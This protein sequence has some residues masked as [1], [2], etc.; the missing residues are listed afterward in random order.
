MRIT[1]IAVRNYRLHRD[2]QIALDPS[3][4][5]IGGLNE[6][7]K[8]TLI[9]AAHRALFLK[10][11][12]NTKEHRAM[13]SDIHSGHP[14][15]EVEFEAR[16]KSWRI[17]KRFSGGSGTAKLTEAGGA[18]LPGDEAETRLRELLGVSEE[19]GK[20]VEQWAH[21]WVWQGSAGENPAEHASAQRDA[22]LARLQKDG[23]A[24]VMRSALDA[25]VA[26][27]VED[28]C[29]LI[30]K[31]SGEAKAGSAP[32]RAQAE[33]AEAEQRLSAAREVAARLEQAAQEFRSAEAAILQSSQSFLDLRP[34]QES[35]EQRAARLVILTGREK[36]Q[37]T[38]VKLAADRLLVLV[39][40]DKNL[41]AL[42][43]DIQR[44]R[45]SLEPGEKDAEEAVAQE[46]AGRE[47]DKKA[48]HSLNAA[49]EAVRAARLCSELAAAHIQCLEKSAAREQLRV[50]LAEV[51]KLRAALAEQEKKLAELPAVDAAALKRLQKLDSE[52][53]QAAAALEAMAARLE[54]IAAGTSVQVEGRTL[55]A[56]ERLILTEDSEVTVGDATRLRIRP[57]G[58]TGLTEA[59]QRV[60]EADAA[61]QRTLDALG[62]RSVTE[63]NEAG[64]LRQQLETE[65]K[66][67][68]ARLEGMGA[69]TL[70]ADVT[71]AE[72][73]ATAA[74]AEVQ[75]RAE[76]VPDFTAP[77]DAAA[78]AS[79]AGESRRQLEEAE[80][81]ESAARAARGVA[82]TTLKDAA[83]R[84]AER[85]SALES[86]RREIADCEAQLRLLLQTHGEDAARA[87]A[88]A[89]RNAARETA[90]AALG[91]TRQ[92]MAA[93]QPELLE[94]DRAR[95]TRAM[96][97]QT[98]AKSAAE[99]KRAAAQSLLLR[100][101]TS[102]PQAD[103]ALAEARA[104]TAA[105][106]CAAE[107]RR[108]HALK[109]LHELFQAEQ[110]ALADQFTA[111]LAA[112]ISGYLEC[113]F[114][115]GARAEVRLEGNEFTSLQLVRPAR[116][117][118][119][120]D[121]ET[122]SGGAKE[123]L[124]AAVR[125][126]MAEVLAEAHE[127]CLPVV[128]DDAFVCADPERVQTVQR[129]LDL[130]ASRGLQI[131]VLTCTPGDYV[132][133]GAKP[134]TL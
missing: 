95:L 20:P 114:G 107:D 51:T 74:A 127:G 15:V 99:Q 16:G 47:R 27:A 106:R 58:G 40:A 44:R 63:A 81:A 14:E 115:P 66:S 121:F 3:R 62:L 134:I 119:A 77:A 50:K 93:L 120:F 125:L 112:K 13:A 85:Q 70:D 97:E 128:F 130:A 30:F 123:Q 118:G 133:L 17:Q 8:S 117:A 1:S 33:S 19:G 52:C 23:G 103:L 12:G 131:I 18:T 29:D 129:M 105:E 36:E 69:A 31:Q 5:L 67:L 54:V 25:K 60:Q 71:A 76:S 43:A 111:P 87:A 22:L 92:A 100:D 104:R 38:E 91:Q 90:E 57:G 7:G 21:L 41:A 32:G 6:S 80:A 4:T 96:K 26:G 116:A 9:E 55:A 64:A 88:L 45:E 126:A 79:L 42:R 109:L 75:R 68:R 102:D 2:V 122:L 28:E 84:L 56:G 98:E 37:S 94:A 39:Q 124:A 86:A 113:L 53:S 61:R 73:A 101:G 24:A 65:I 11:K 10:A 78:A 49:A 59:R 46:A 48:E 34:Q 82:A 72:S 35:V 108:A 132:A 89:E 110:Q 83:D